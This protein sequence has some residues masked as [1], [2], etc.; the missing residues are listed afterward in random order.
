LH[1]NI[2]QI[3]SLISNPGIAKKL[4]ESGKI[5]GVDVL[6]FGHFH[7]PIVQKIDVLLLSPGSA[8]VP[9]IAELSAI[10]LDIIKNTVKGK[11]IRCKD[12]VC[13]YFEY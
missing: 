10:E 3:I 5:M 2:L 4:V 13:T 6:V 7:H 9:G 8:T 1:S 12:N 11:I